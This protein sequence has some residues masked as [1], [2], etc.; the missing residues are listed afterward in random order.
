MMGLLLAFELGRRGA[1]GWCVAVLQQDPRA[2]RATRCASA[3]MSTSIILAL[4]R[5]VPQGVHEGCCTRR[6]RASHRGGTCGS[7]PGSYAQ[8]HPAHDSM[9][10]PAQVTSFGAVP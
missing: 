7:C 10:A 6:R 1:A 9:W 2:T 4:P 8:P 3:N 5:M